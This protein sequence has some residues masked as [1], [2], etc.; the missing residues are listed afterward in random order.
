MVSHILYDRK[1]YDENIKLKK[2]SMYSESCTPPFL[3]QIK[4]TNFQSEDTYIKVDTTPEHTRILKT[5]A[6]AELSAYGTTV[7]CKLDTRQL[8]ST[9][10][11]F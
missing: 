2:D 9:M 7:N 5:L 3:N 10:S 1:L 8:P 6:T 4:T 11:V